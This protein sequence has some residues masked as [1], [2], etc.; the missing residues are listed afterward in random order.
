MPT[1]VAAT[2]TP[3]IDS[4]NTRTIAIPLDT[5]TSFSTRQVFAR[6]YSVTKIRTEDGH[7]GLGF[8]YAGSHGG[9]L[10]SHALRTLFRDRLVGQNALRTDGIWHDLYQDTLL[11]GRAGP[12][13]RAWTMVDI[14]LWDRN[15]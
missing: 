13:M 5:P 1:D 6:E 12:A 15:A 10:V 3:K 11:H 14:A 7:E 2:Q 9:T 8:C 4:V